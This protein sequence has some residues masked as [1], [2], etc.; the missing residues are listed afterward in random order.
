[1][2]GHAS[3]ANL[4]PTSLGRLNIRRVGSG[5]PALLWH[6]LWVDSGSWG[7]L[8]DSLGAHRQV[9]AVDG[10]GYGGSDPIHRDFTLDDCANAAV[11]VLDYLGITGPADWVGNAWCGHVGITL[12]AGRPARVRSLVTINAPLLP[13]GRRQR[14]TTS[15]P[16]ALL[17]RLIGPSAVIAKVLFDT[18]LGSDAIEAQP[19]R[20]ADIVSAF[21]RADRGSM[22]ATIRF[23]HHWQPLTDKLPAITAPTL[24]LTG[25]VDGQQWSPARAQ[26]AAATM[27]DARVVTLTGAGHVSPLL[28][29]TDL[30][31]STVAD[32]W[33]ST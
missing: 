23:M 17:Y 26:A 14:L 31:A 18:L 33:Q 1:M 32:F 24:F 10:P 27:L 15:Y 21:K 5:P 29:D 13:V 20:A 16:L 2:D 12:A 22:Q 6:S 7:P 8:V 19:H 4:V 25:D 9:V 30:I 28:L 11:E 3:E